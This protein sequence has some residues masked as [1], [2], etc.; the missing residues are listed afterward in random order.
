MR[1]VDDEGH[2]ANYIETEQLVLYHGHKASFV[3][4]RAA[5]RGHVEIGQRKRVHVQRKVLKGCFLPSRLVAPFL[6]SG[7]RG[8]P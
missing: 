6:S 4:V 8:Q 7:P 2:V 3:Q 1:G 5:G